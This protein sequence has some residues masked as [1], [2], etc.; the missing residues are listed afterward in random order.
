MKKAERTEM[1]T[2]HRSVA[3]ERERLMDYVDSRQEI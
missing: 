1:R 2:S 3:E